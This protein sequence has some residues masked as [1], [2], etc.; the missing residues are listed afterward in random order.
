MSLQTNHDTV[1]ADV[2]MFVC[3]ASDLVARRYY[4][5]PT[6]RFTND[7]SLSPESVM[8]TSWLF[9]FTMWL[10]QKFVILYKLFNV[11]ASTL[12][13]FTVT[14]PRRLMTSW[15]NDLG[16]SGVGLD[17][18]GVSPINSADTSRIHHYKLLVVLSLKTFNHE[19]AQWKPPVLIDKFPQQCKVLV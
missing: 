1:K 15:D 8:T 18:T 10:Y 4:I 12:P 11:V 7:T 3:S 6:Q 14:I 2:D 17:L 13:S 16:D 5:F 9:V 19:T